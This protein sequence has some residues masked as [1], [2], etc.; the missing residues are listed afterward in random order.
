[1]YKLLALI[2]IDELIDKVNMIEERIIYKS[3]TK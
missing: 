3:L 1:M 2:S